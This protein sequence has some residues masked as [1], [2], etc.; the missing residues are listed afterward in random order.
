MRA[1]SLVLALIGFCAAAFGETGTQ[2]AQANRKYEE[3][4][5]PE[6]KQLYEELIQRGTCSSNLFYNLA[7]TEFR[8]GQKGKAAL[9]YE[10]ALLLNPAHPEALANLKL[11]RSQTNAQIDQRGWRSLFGLISGDF[12]LILAAVSFWVVAW[13]MA[14]G[15]LKGWSG[16]SKFVL[17]GS[18]MILAYAGLGFWLSTQQREIALVIAERAEPR[19]APTDR[20][21]Q[22]SA[23]TAGSRVRLLAD[24]GTWVYCLLPDGKRGWLQASTVEPLFPR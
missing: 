4:H 21:A 2:F 8:L 24:R 19:F 16:A 10:R 18:L 20:A 11:L 13:F 9:N 17:A 7:N 12:A 3:G 15:L 5:Y 6:A 14:V 23:L 22:V 1:A